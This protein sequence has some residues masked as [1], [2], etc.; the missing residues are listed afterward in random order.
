MGPDLSCR[1]NARKYHMS[2][3]GRRNSLGLVL[4]ERGDPWLSGTMNAFTVL[5]FGNSHSAPNFRAPL[6]EGRLSVRETAFVRSTLSKLQTD[7]ATSS[8]SSPY[9]LAQIAAS[10]QAGTEHPIVG[11]AR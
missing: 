5:L 6:C 9:P 8:P 3:R 4:G 7:H 2:T 11:V 10:A 1:G